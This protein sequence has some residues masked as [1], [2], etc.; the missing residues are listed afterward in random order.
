MDDV[1]AIDKM[2]FIRTLRGLGAN[3]NLAA[4]VTFL[5]GVDEAT[6]KDIQD[7]AGISQPG[8]SKAMKALRELGWLEVREIKATGNGRPRKIYALNVSL[9]EVV[10]HFEVQKLSESAQAMRSIERLR[11]LASS[12]S[13]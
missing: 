7:G 13:P 5:A 4:A 1:T 2:E 6:A 3:R 12:S 8:V 9:E 10:R 11:E